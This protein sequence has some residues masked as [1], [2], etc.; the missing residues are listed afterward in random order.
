MDLEDIR[1]QVDTLDKDIIGL[2]SKRAE[3]VSAAGKLKKDEKGVRDPKRVEQVI[4]KIKAKAS[5]AGLEPALAEEIYRTIIGCFVRKEL[6]EYNRNA[7]L[8]ASLARGRTGSDVPEKEKHLND[9]DFEISTDKDRLD[10]GMIHEFLSKRSYWAKGIPLEVV[11]RSIEH[12]LCFGLYQQGKQVGFARVVT[13]RATVAYLADVFI[14]EPYRGRG[15]G[16]GLVR[17]IIDHPDLAGLRMW[18]LGTKDAHELYA[19]YG[20]RKVADTAAHDRFMVILNPD[21]Y[22]RATAGS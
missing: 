13:D 6:A 17:A 4:E 1:R 5:A 12:A 16:K 22:K 8:P 21:A 3:L 15:L 20:F 10:L 2:I 7:P 18:I 19:K 9:R 14:L 11:K